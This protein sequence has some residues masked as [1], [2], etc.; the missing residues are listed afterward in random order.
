[1]QAK[2]RW[3]QVGAKD[4]I[5][6]RDNFPTFKINESTQWALMWNQ[7]AAGPAADF[8]Y[9]FSILVEARMKN[10]LE[11]EIQMANPKREAGKEC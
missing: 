8:N 7:W 4:A 9:Y 10:F 5:V 3:S 11:S 2:S 6:A 1:M